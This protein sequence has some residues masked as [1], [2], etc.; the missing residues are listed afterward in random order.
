MPTGTLA[1][2]V[3]RA[4]ATHDEAGGH[5]GLRRQPDGGGT[6]DRADALAELLRL[7]VRDVVV[8]GIADRPATEACYAAGVGKTLALKMGGTIDPQ[9]SKPVEV[10]ATVVFLATTDKPPERQAVVDVDGVTLVLT[11]RRRPFHE[12][13]DFTSLGLDPKAFQIV[14]VKAGYLVPEHRRDR[15]PEP[16]GAHRRSRQP[17]HRAPVQQSPRAQLSLREGLDLVAHNDCRRARQAL[18]GGPDLALAQRRASVAGS[19][20]RVHISR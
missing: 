14:V 8:A 5:L 4:Q 2:I 12:I 11:A 18:S 15:Q 20:G 19:A 16:D 7:K 6:G 3:T 17:G 13:E 1:E 10:A 9:Q